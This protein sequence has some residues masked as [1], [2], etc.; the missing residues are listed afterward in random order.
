MLGGWE[1]LGGPVRVRGTTG[2]REVPSAG[3]CG[4]PSAG[5]YEVL[6]GTVIGTFMYLF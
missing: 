5:Y 6:Q 1:V 2:Y 4:V 3:Y